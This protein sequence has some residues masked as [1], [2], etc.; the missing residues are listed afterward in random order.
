[1]ELTPVGLPLDWHE[2]GTP[3]FLR[4]DFIRPARKMIPHHSVIYDHLMLPEHL[5]LLPELRFNLFVLESSKNTT[6]EIWLGKSAID[7]KRGYIFGRI[8]QALD[9]TGRIIIQRSSDIGKVNDFI[10]YSLQ[11][12]QFVVI[13]A[14]YECVLLNQS[15]ETPARFVELQSREEV[16]DV[17]S[18]TLLEGSGYR[19]K[20]D[21]KLEPNSNYDELPIPVIKPAFDEFRFIRRRPLYEMITS[22]PQGFDFIDPPNE[23]FYTGSV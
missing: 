10:I 3:I 19:Q 12:L 14:N 7:E 11:P 6:E 5:H 16:R 18:L 8:I 17:S 4:G 1:M 20:I 21:G 23:S 22:F 9:S 2:D 15:R 13:P